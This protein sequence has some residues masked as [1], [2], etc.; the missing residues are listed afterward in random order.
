M[1]LRAIF[2]ILIFFGICNEV[3]YSAARTSKK[4]RGGKGEVV[5]AETVEEIVRTGNVKRL[6]QLEL[7]SRGEVHTCFAKSGY[8]QTM[9]E[10]RSWDFFCA[11][12]EMQLPGINGG[13]QCPLERTPLYLA[14]HGEK[15]CWAEAVPELLT[16]PRLN[17]YVRGE[18]GL[19]ADDLLGGEDY[20][21]L[22]AIKE[23]K[24]TLVQKVLE[25]Q[26]CRLCKSVF[27]CPDQVFI[28]SCG[29][30]HAYHKSC[31]QEAYAAG[32]SVSCYCCKIEICAGDIAGLELS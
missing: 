16:H 27:S 28:L 18:D 23:Y 11:C 10:R 3:L 31:L 19:I 26:R 2:Y 30:D 17:P 12:I 14:L 7:E 21:I 20:E 22:E 13:S 29:N 15:G 25:E 32:K 8:W 5:S 1:K 4:G 24:E 6:R 9:I